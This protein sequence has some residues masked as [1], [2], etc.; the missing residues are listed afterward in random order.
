[1]AQAANGQ[2]WATVLAMGG[3]ERKKDA[4]KQTSKGSGE[5][6]GKRT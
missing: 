3:K 4:V 1:M 2:S 5:G 6:F